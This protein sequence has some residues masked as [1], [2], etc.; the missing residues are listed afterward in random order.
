MFKDRIVERLSAWWPGVPKKRIPVCVCCGLISDHAAGLPSGCHCY[1]SRRDSVL[2]LD[3]VCSL[4][5]PEKK[6]PKLVMLIPSRMFDQA[7]NIRSVISS[8]LLSHALTCSPCLSLSV[9]FPR[10]VPNWTGVPGMR[11]AC[12]CIIILI[13]CVPDAWSPPT[14]C[15]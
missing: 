13:G 15:S 2:T 4:F 3:L 7:C 10:I 1:A 12:H 5:S 9:S 14:R 6:E 8:S 11:Q